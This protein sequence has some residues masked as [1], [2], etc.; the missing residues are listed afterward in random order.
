MLKIRRSGICSKTKQTKSFKKSLTAMIFPTLSSLSSRTVA[1][2]AEAPPDFA[3]SSL[4]IFSYFSFS[5][6]GRFCNQES[7]H[8][9]LCHKS[10]CFIALCGITPF[11]NSTNRLE[12]RFYDQQRPELFQAK[13]D[14]KQ[15]VSL[16]LYVPPNRP[17]KPFVINHQSIRFKNL[18]SPTSVV[19]KVFLNTFKVHTD[20]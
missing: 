16:V 7:K 20:K 11:P 19:S 4:A 2:D 14:C 15:R 12:P 1:V 9:S 13:G 18:L 3:F 8:Q 17:K 6:G 5:A 10:L